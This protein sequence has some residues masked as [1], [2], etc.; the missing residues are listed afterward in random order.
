MSNSGTREVTYLDEEW[1]IQTTNLK[2]K[3]FYDIIPYFDKLK[4]SIKDVVLI[5][6]IDD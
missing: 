1:E 2:W 3:N 5:I 4:Q 6:K